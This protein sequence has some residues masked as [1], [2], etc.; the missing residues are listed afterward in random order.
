MKSTTKL[1]LKKCELKKILE[2]WKNKKWKDIRT[3]EMIK[4]SLKIIEKN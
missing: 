4:I 3:L 2:Y 1:K